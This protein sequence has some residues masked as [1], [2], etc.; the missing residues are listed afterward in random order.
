MAIASSEVDEIR[1]KMAF[2]RR[3]LHEDV[4]GVVEGA[5]EATDWRHYVRMY[6]WAAV[7]TALAVGYLAVPKRKKTVKPA[8][9]ARA[10]VAE[11][12]QASRPAAAEEPS[13][14][15]HGL[16]GAG[17]ALLTPVLL[18][19]AQNYATHFITHWIA[20]QQEAHMAGMMADPGASPQQ[21]GPETGYGMAGGTSRN[22]GGPR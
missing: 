17:L 11:M 9:V 4:K 20:Q 12:P 15:G 18:R 22:P 1:R 16:I 3:E 14:K 10:V 21:P 13:K 2:V 19:A 7:A 6:P 5:E 8:E